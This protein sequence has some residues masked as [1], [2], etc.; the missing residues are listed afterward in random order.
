MS[1]LEFKSGTF[2][3]FYA[4]YFCSCR[5][6]CLLVLWCVGDR[7]DMADSDENLGRSRRPGADDRG[8]SSICRVLRGRVI[9]RSGDAMCNL[10]H[11]HGDKERVF[12]G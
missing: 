3:W 12:L 5:E 1:S 11:A 10:Y 9:R 8:W 4:F 7:C 2:P 6:S